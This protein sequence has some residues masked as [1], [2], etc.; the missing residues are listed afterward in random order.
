MYELEIEEGDPQ[1]MAYLSDRVCP[2][3]GREIREVVPSRCRCA[4]AYPCGHKVL[5]GDDAL[6]RVQGLWRERSTLRFDSEGRMAAPSA[7]TDGDTL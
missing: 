1:W 2:R 7:E 5:R 6:E 4:V 3:C